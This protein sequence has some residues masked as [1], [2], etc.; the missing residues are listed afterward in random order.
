MKKNFKKIVKFN[1]YYIIALIVIFILG[2]S[3]TYSYYAYNYE[4]SVAIKG[5]VIAIDADLT[6]ELVVGNNGQMVPLKDS[7]LSNALNAVDT[8]NGAC[9]DKYG[10]LA[11]QVYKITLHNN[12]SRLQNIKGTIEL[13][14]KDSSSTYTNLKWRELTN[15]TTIKN[16]S[17]INGMDKSNLVTG[18]T[19]DSGEEV[20]YYIAVYIQ[21]VNTDQ[22]NNDKGQ[23]QGTVTFE[24]GDGSGTSTT[25]NDK[26]K[27]NATLDTNIDFSKISSDTN[28]KGVYIRSG[29]E[30]DTNPIYYYRGDVDNNNLIFADTCWK[31]VRTTETGG[32]KLIYNGVPS[33][34]TC[35]NTGSASQIGTKAFNSSYTS[36]AYV[37]YM[38]GTPYTYSSKRMSSVSDTY[39]Y[40]NDVT[41]SNGTYTLTDTIS[42]SSWSS[43]YNSGLNNNHYT[44][45]GSTTCSTV[46]YIYYT[47]SSTMYYISLSNGKKVED[48]LSDMLDNNTTSSTIKGSSSS[49]GTID[50]WYYTN[51]EQ[52]G[53]SEYLED[54]VWCNDRSISQLNG[55]DPNGGST[56]S[57]LYFSARDRAYITYTPDL[58][59]SREI[60]RFTV[61]ESNGNGDLDYPV[62]LITADEIML[63]GGK[64]GISNSSYYLYTGQY[65][66]A[67]S[68]S[69]FNDVYANGFNVDSTGVLNDRSVANA[70]GARPLVSLRPGTSI[71]GGDGTSL[72]PFTIE[73]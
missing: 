69:G 11:C 14:A 33:N 19:L 17:I 12:G 54:T 44:C 52:K 2:V 27:E 21:E 72:S 18:L 41:Y 23:F 36:P 42:S 48:A 67:G 38:Y 63:A 68:P 57:Y 58:S 30:N 5:N 60:D 26:I 51:I 1:K 65:W 62:G 28:G 47:S 71:S 73:N 39:Y 13:Y 49:S 43:I 70:Y 20:V 55:W 7:S 59:C 10:N 50:N 3:T 6:V 15:T 29:T 56:R 31:I 8:P 24:T 46:Y 34:G 4:N 22:I 25:L 9:V 37:G 40:G 32:T 53:Y 64:T 35:N 16:G 66:W 61:S 45:M